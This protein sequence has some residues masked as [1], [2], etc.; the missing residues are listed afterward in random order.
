MTIVVTG[1]GSGG[2]ITPIL[3]VARE[4]KKIRPDVR[5]VYVSQTNDPL[6]DIPG[7]D[8]NI[9]TIEHVR[10]GKFRRYHGEGWRQLL[11]LETISLNIRDAA[12]IVI[13]VWQSFWLLR[14]LK[15]GI[16]F[17]RGS[18][19][20]VPVCLAAALL[21]I[22]YVT[23]DSDAIPS[24][25]NKI[26]ARWATLHA[27]A[28][29]E[30]FYPY[31]IDTT[32]TVGVPIS[33]DY[34][35]VDDKLR[36][37]YKRELKINGYE[38]VLLITG[39]GLGA[40]SLN[41]AIIASASFLLKRYP[42]LMIIH[43]TGRMHE[44]EVHAGYDA[45]LEG[46]EER[47]RVMIKGFVTDFYRYSGAATIV[48]ARGGATNLAELAVQAKPSII[49]PAPHLTGGHQLKNTA[50]LEKQGAIIKIT[51]EQLEQELRLA[52]VISTLLDHPQKMQEL[53]ANFAAI[54]QP[55]AA[56]KIADMLL[57]TARITHIENREQP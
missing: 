39:G 53:S 54:A 5:I 15:P 20:S 52:N 16:I 8:K 51:E 7:Q 25:T 17:T 13:G 19:V 32:V 10:A 21:R 56:R 11:D 30:E 12:W 4:L 43:I 23:H 42:G 28:L 38:H 49:V 41:A 9:E 46:P 29:P 44:A 2:H 55:D 36:N 27:V 40:L 34:T 22:P 31:P 37:Q 33:A 47:S 24:L 35:K 45:V 26:I 48:V 6:D 50:A 18:Y 57:Q 3:A 1:G 14:K